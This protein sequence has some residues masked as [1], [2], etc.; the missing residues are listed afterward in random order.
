MPANIILR[1]DQPNTIN[2]LHKHTPF[3]DT[4]IFCS[5]GS[6]SNYTFT[7]A[8]L[9]RNF[10]RKLQ[11]TLTALSALHANDYVNVTHSVT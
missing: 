4:G 5:A 8:I 1:S 2:Q 11:E 9:V 10:A 6:L 3:V 7:I